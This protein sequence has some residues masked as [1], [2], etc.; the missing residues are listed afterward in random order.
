LWKGENDV[1]GLVNYSKLLHSEDDKILNLENNEAVT[2]IPTGGSQL[3]YYI[4]KKY[5]DGLL[6]AQVHI[7]DSD[8]QEYID[9]VAAL[10]AEG[11]PKKVG[12]NTIKSELENYLH[13]D[14]INECYEEHNIAISLTEVLDSDDVPER[15]AIAVHSAAGGDW[16]T[17]NPDPIKNEEKRKKKIS[18][19]KRQLNM[20]AIDKMTVERLRNRG[21]YDEIKNWLDKI[22]EFI[23]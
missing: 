12:F 4:E 17:I 6:Q 11:N 7:Y 20:A 22:N 15:V 18:R 8:K 3:K 14:A 10:N 2:F 23:N 5:L 1:N 9:S 21:G 13:H 19:A 16:A